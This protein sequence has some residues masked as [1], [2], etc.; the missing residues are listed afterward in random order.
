[1]NNKGKVVG[2]FMDEKWLWDLALLCDISHHLNK[3][4]QGQINSLLMKL[5]WKEVENVNLCHVFSCDLFLNGG[6][7]SVPFQSVCT[8]KNE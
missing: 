5:F 4:L 8:G 7:V 6:S 1:M 3:K 2:Q